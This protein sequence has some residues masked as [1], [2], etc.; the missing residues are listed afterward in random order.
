MPPLLHIIQHGCSRLFSSSFH[1]TGKCIWQLYF[2]NQHPHGFSL[3][4][5]TFPVV[6]S[7]TWP[8]GEIYGASSTGKTFREMFLCVFFFGLCAHPMKRGIIVH[9]LVCLSH[10][11]MYCVPLPLFKMS[12]FISYEENKKRN[13][14]KSDGADIPTGNISKVLIVKTDIYPLNSYIG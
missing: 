8:D 12:R 6:L 1:F 2:S 11:I 5:A 7:N 4:E 14:I 13:T 10:H 9:H 3:F